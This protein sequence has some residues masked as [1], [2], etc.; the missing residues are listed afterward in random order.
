MVLLRPALSQF[1]AALTLCTSVSDTRAVVTSFE[2]DRGYTHTWDSAKKARVCTR[3]G[4]GGLSLHQLGM[5]A[6][7]LVCYWGL[8]GI[9]GSDFDPENP[10][11]G[12]I[13]PEADP[14]AE[15]AGFFEGAINMSPGCWKNPRGCFR[16]DYELMSNVTD[17]L[18][19]DRVDFI[20]TIDNGNDPHMRELEE[21]K[22]IKTIFVD[23]F[24][25]FSPECRAK[26][27][28]LL[29]ESKCYGRSMIDV[30]QR[31]EEL[32]I[33]LG[34][35][36]DVPKTEAAKRD[37]C[38]AAAAFSA[39]MKD[40]HAKDMRI[41]V[42]ILG[43]TEYPADSGTNV[44]YAR[45]FDPI[46]LWVPR[47]LE[48]LGAPL[49][50]GGTY[51]KTA[52]EKRD[53]VVDKFFLDC[54]DGLVNA[55][56]KDNTYH[57]VDFWLI[58]SRSYLVL[59]DWVNFDLFPDPA[60]LAGQFSYYPRND[61]ALSYR[62][63]A[64]L[65]NMYNDKISSAAKVSKS[66]PGE[67]TPVDPKSSEIISKTGGLE[68]NDFICYNEGLIQKEYLVCPPSPPTANGDTGSTTPSPPDTGGETVSATTFPPGVG[69]ET[70]STATS[71]PDADD[72]TVSTKDSNSGS[73]GA[74][75]LVMILSSAVVV[76]GTFLFI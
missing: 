19:T 27:Y 43:T 64:S 12:S 57:P 8:W 59:E 49:L 25:E 13:Y 46:T 38:A 21:E 17:L 11:A 62:M 14:T 5:Q 68:L 36:V 29:D 66:N 26:N 51:D 42:S 45:D 22:G 39:S 58:D 10:A 63:I 31:I 30:V 15:E 24:Y 18:E 23:T 28:T 67:C 34:V 2:D 48:E 71:A 20:L 54:D 53:I 7:Q 37:A 4:V 3:A 44:P 76:A 35:D 56:C 65:L 69:G 60:I 6:E 16:W 9:R 73:N 33:F 1:L 74:A 41:K 40:A 55:T 70:I 47:T 52:G 50:H 61:G 75:S 32:A 72:E